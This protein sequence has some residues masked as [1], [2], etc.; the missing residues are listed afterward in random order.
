MNNENG[1]PYRM[2]KAPNYTNIYRGY[3]IKS[4]HHATETRIVISH[5]T[6]KAH[7]LPQFTGCT[8]T[9]ND[10]SQVVDCSVENWEAVCKIHIDNLHERNETKG[11]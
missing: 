9:R 2:V 4:N 10:F 3:H 8:I 5:I 11:N 7:I 6:G 1:N